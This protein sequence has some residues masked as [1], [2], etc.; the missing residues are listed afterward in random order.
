MQDA[1]IAFE[2][3]FFRQNSASAVMQ[4]S[5]AQKLEPLIDLGGEDKEE[6][7]SAK[8]AERDFDFFGNFT[9]GRKENQAFHANALVSLPPQGKMGVPPIHP[10]F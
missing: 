3:F 2:D 8:A 5:S 1:A 7:K 9:T 4:P 6:K 10:L